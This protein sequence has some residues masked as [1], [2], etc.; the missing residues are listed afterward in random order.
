MHEPIRLSESGKT[1]VS[2]STQSTSSYRSGLTPVTR[3]I[4]LKNSYSKVVIRSSNITFCMN[5][6]ST[7]WLSRLPRLPGFASPASSGLP[8]LATSTTG[9]FCCFDRSTVASS[10]A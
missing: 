10:Y 2:A 6:M 5:A 9:T 4:E 1:F 8:H 3:Q 7:I